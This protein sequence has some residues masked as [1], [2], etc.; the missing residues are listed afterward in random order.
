MRL[1]LLL[2]GCI[3]L[4]G[5][6]LAQDNAGW[7]QNSSSHDA[8]RDH[9]Y[10][11]VTGPASI[12]KQMPLHE[13][14]SKDLVFYAMVALVLFYA[15]IQRAFPKYMQD[16][17]RLFFRTTLKQRHLSEQLS[18]TPLPSFLLNIFFFVLAGFYLS[19]WVEQTG[20]NPFTDFWTLFTYLL[21]GVA[22]AYLVKFSV[23]RLTGWLFRAKEATN[24]YVFTVFTI[25]K[26]AGIFLLPLI[27]VMAFAV[28]SVFAIA[29]L[30]SWVVLIALLLYRLLLSF[31]V[32]R[33]QVQ[34][35]GFHFLLY[36]AGFEMAPLLIIYKV[37]LLNFR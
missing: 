11:N 6:L 29:L 33:K 13:S 26:M 14:A 4:S 7:Y 36:V 35:S 12:Q 23:L 31:R 24:S 18:Q 28:P 34:L 21:M 16:L 3:F 1:F 25:N 27:V 2:L 5:G 9:P 22:A 17:F 20:H 15:I 10:F 30:L 8:L 32:V 19:L 37:I